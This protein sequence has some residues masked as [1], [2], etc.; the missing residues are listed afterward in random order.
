[1]E[2]LHCDF[3]AKIIFI[4]KP[5]LR[6]ITYVNFNLIGTLGN[7]ISDFKENFEYKK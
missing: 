3:P 5:R 6:T 1:M 7:E 4:R 2:I